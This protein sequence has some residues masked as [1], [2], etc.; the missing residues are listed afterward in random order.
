MRAPSLDQD[1]SP[2]AQGSAGDGVSTGVKPRRGFTLI[3]L[4]VVIALIVLLAAMLLPVL[5]S[6]RDRARQSACLSN[7]QQI[8]QAHLLYLQDWDEQFP[9]WY[10]PATPRPQPFGARS[11]WTEF[12]QPYLRSKPVFSDPSARWNGPED[13]RLADYVLV[14]WGPG[15]FGTPDAPYYHWPGPPLSLAQVGRPTETFSVLDGWSTTA[16]STVESWGATGWTAERPLRHS[17][18]TNGCF[19]DGHARWLPAGELG[20]ADTDGSGVYWLHYGSANR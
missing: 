16:G 7:L 12:L 18:G 14:T 4:L 8:G 15:G 3:E 9:Y 2:A 6:V 1:V 5:G 10:L 20:R 19:L 11:Y 13:V 17:G